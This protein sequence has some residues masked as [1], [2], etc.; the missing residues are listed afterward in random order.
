VRQ[1]FPVVTPHGLIKNQKRKREKEKGENEGRKREER[2][3][4]RRKGEKTDR[5]KVFGP[6]LESVVVRQLFPVVTPHGL[7]KG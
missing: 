4:G 6:R 3:K 5:G 1:L 2:E 7:I